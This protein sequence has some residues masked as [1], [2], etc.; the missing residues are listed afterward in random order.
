MT[1]KKETFFDT[2]KVVVFLVVLVW[3]Q[4]GGIYHSATKHSSSDL[5]LTI[6][7]PP[8][9]WYR[10]IEFF[11]HDDFAGIDWDKRLENDFKVA[12]EISKNTCND[13]NHLST[14]NNKIYLHKRIKSYPSLQKSK[15]EL[16]VLSYMKYNFQV[17]Q[18]MQKIM[19]TSGAQASEWVETEYMKTQRSVF[20]KYFTK[21]EWK[22]LHNAH[23]QSFNKFIQIWPTLG[24]KEK[25]H[26]FSKMKDL[27][28]LNKERY[29]SLYKDLF[30]K[31]IR[32]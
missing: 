5:V 22:I 15:I 16:A 6:L 4:F 17:F 13:I 21:T 8:Y 25:E 31:E 7:I 14:N 26:A 24:N 32:L 9:S 29:Q 28:N 12:V 2:I 23:E 1:Q 30:D 18:V 20:N 3:L 10:S 27:S 11:W 19:N